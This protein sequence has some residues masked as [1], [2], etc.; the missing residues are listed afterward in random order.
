MPGTNQL[1]TSVLKIRTEDKSSLLLSRFSCQAENS[2]GQMSYNIK[3][4]NEGRHYIMIT[5]TF[6]P[7][8]HFIKKLRFQG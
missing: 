4:V 8:F 1:Y 7:D 5:A 6:S 2:Q 3:I